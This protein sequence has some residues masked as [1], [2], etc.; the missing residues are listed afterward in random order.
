L[1]GKLLGD[2][3]D[4]ELS[5]SITGGTGTRKPEGSVEKTRAQTTVKAESRL[6]STMGAPPH[7]E[8]RD[9]CRTLQ[10]LGPGRRR[11][12]AALSDYSHAAVSFPA[13]R[14]QPPCVAATRSLERQLVEGYKSSGLTDLPTRGY[15]IPLPRGATASRRAL[16]RSSCGRREEELRRPAGARDGARAYEPKI[17]AAE[18]FTFECLVEDLHL[19]I[20][21]IHRVDDPQISALAI[22]RLER[23][24]G[25]PAASGPVRPPLLQ[26]Q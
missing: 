3:L 12:P 7:C 22:Q 21:F 6:F 26:S 18:T 23:W 13:L 11:V 17:D 19:D 24:A 10:R 20:E 25:A 8:D 16:E 5:W 4:L 15:R 9:N 1:H 14:T 2:T